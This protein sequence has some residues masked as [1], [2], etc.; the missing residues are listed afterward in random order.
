MQRTIL[1]AVIGLGLIAPAFALEHVVFE[2][3][4]ARQRVSG[5]V[6]VTDQQGGVL[7]LSRDGKLRTIEKKDLIDRSRDDVPFKPLSQDALA[8]A[9]LADL[10]KGFEVYRTKHYVICHNTSQAYAAWCGALFERLHRNFINFWS[11]K[12]V[13]LHEP[14]FPLAA[15]VFADQ[16]SYQKYAQWE[17]GE[18]AAAT[19]G[20]YSLHTNHI[21]MYDLTSIDKLRRPGDR[22][23]TSGQINAMLSR[24]A[25]ERTT[26]T[27][28][29]E[30]THQMAFNCGLQ[31]RYAD[32]PVWLS[33]GIAMYFETPDLKSRKGWTT[34]GAMNRVKLAAFKRYLP[35]RPAA[36]L[37]SLLV[38]DARF[39]NTR[40]AAAAYAEA[41]AL[42]YYL[43]KN[44]QTQR[45]LIGYL[46][47]LGKKPRLE[48][49]KPEQRLKE[50]EAAFGDIGKLDPLFL[51]KLKRLR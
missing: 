6:L 30:A 14:E 31:T 39:R 48:W 18:A 37:K 4:G 43:M 44:K 21:T 19:F 10:P 32:V 34:I 16:Q 42:T 41:W 7:L 17:L 8:A 15:I 22:R 12:G 50:F 9:V 28:V 38:T 46:K 25:G 3:D 23:L 2:K 35:Q 5:K 13:K 27:I 51:R 40:Q 24:P 45:K 36:S 1:A 47:M 26:A 33:E 11:R 49:D 29:H 20:L